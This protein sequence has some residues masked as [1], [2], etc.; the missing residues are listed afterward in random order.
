MKKTSKD[1]TTKNTRKATVSHNYLKV[2]L[3]HK[4]I[5]KAMIIMYAIYSEI[6]IKV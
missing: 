6:Y 1:T 5:H 3:A 4:K 2:V